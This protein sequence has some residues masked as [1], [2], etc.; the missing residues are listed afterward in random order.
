MTE[1]FE[2]V[3]PCP[4]CRRPMQLNTSVSNESFKQYLCGCT[5]KVHFVNKHKNQR[6][7]N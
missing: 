1:D 2:S 7:K 5:G 3:P 4:N 6:G